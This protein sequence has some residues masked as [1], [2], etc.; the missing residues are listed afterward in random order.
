M[1]TEYKLSYTGREIDEKLGKI[2]RLE[3]TI[4]NTLD[5]NGNAWFAG[6]VYVGGTNQND[7]M[8]LIKENDVATN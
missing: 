6:D 8:K 3:S 2:D 5:V 7:A 1:P 4:D